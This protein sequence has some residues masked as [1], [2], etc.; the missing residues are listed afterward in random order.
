[1]KPEKI[2][3][4]VEK[5]KE[6][7]T[8]EKVRG[9]LD[10]LIGNVDVEPTIRVRVKGVIVELPSDILKSAL[11]NKRAEVDQDLSSL[12]TEISNL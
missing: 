4:L 8:K 10:I 1:M 11:E 7:E 2:K 3:E 6:K 5:H 12:N 9:E